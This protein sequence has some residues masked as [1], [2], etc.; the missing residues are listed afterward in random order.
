MLSWMFL[1]YTLPNGDPYSVTIPKA[2]TSKIYGAVY[3][4][5][6]SKSTFWNI[7]PLSIQS[8]STRISSVSFGVYNGSGYIQAYLLFY[9]I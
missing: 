6:S 9:G 4:M 5:V 8:F 1:S 3:S 2:Y 7:N